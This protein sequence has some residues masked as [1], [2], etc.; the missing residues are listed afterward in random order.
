MKGWANFAD[1]DFCFSGMDHSDHKQV[2]S[3][4]RSPRASPRKRRYKQGSLE[5]QLSTLHCQ[6]GPSSL[7]ELFD[8]P[9]Q[10]VA[11]MCKQPELLARACQLLE[12]GIVH[13]SDY[14]GMLAERAG[15]CLL[16]QALCEEAM[17]SV[18][19]T[20]TRACDIDR[21]CQQLLLHSAQKQDQGQSCVFQDIREQIDPRGQ[22]W[23]QAC[24]SNPE[25]G[26]ESCAAAYNSMDEF[27]EANGSWAVDQAGFCCP[28]MSC[29]ILGEMQCLLLS[30]YL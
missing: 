5:D 8:F 18:P 15:M 6:A 22:A 16:L 21:D 3:D 9:K 30:A 13:S 25:D 19:Y 4:L 23:C 20:F 10:H 2:A 14:A 26:P 24:L 11:T 28:A 29:L 12:H 17:C 27:L 7:S 1:D